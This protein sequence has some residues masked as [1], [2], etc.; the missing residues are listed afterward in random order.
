MIQDNCFIFADTSDKRCHWGKE[1][2][3]EKWISEQCEY[4]PGKTIP[5]KLNRVADQ[6][7]R[8][9]NCSS[10]AHHTKRVFPTDVMTFV[11]LTK[12]FTTEWIA[13]WGLLREKQRE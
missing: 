6:I 1:M 13:S 10:K 2:S 8:Q 3:Q 4:I 11:V 7:R 12:T 5:G 9:M